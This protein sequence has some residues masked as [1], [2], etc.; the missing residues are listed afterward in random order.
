MSRARSH[1]RRPVRALATVGLAAT[2]LLAVH[3]TPASAAP[4]HRVLR[5]GTLHGVAG[6]FRTIQAAVDA[7][8][9]GD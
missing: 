6:Q 2:T 8:R 4:H 1:L 7:A 3:T 9:P 5:V